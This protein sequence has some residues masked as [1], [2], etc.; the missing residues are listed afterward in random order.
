MMH[1]W[2]WAKGFLVSY[3]YVAILAGGSPEEFYERKLGA[4]AA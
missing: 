4:M 1:V 3:D 2:D